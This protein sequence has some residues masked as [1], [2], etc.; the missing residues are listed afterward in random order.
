MTIPLGVKPPGYVRRHA[1]R[2]EAS[3]GV[4]TA[5]DLLVREHDLFMAV[6][7]AFGL[8]GT[9]FAIFSLVA[10]TFNFDH[11]LGFIFGCFGTAAWM[12]AFACWFFFGTGQQPKHGR[13]R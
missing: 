3:V 13:P 10:Y 5:F 12:G 4:K 11:D 7:S 6:V 1:R 8:L 2:S 9:V